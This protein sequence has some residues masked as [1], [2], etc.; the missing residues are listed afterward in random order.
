MERK[1]IIDADE[2]GATNM[3]REQR[4]PVLINKSK[5]ISFDKEIRVHDLE[6]KEDQIYETN[7]YGTQ[8]FA[9][10]GNRRDHR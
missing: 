10:R 6:T 9:R 3:K 8:Y 2:V 4:Y 1:E 7:D 5:K